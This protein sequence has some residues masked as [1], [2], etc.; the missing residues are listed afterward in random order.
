MEHSSK[1]A[2]P[3]QRLQL[4]VMKFAQDVFTSLLPLMTIRFPPPQTTFASNAEHGFQ[5]V[6]Q[7]LFDT[8]YRTPLCM[9]YRTSSWV[10]IEPVS[11]GSIES[12]VVSFVLLS[13]MR[14]NTYWYKQFIMKVP[15]ADS[16]SCFDQL[17]GSAEPS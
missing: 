9:L 7:E 4:Y 16:R 1:P 3:I 8:F 14:L 5:K 10:S 15:E 6:S 2:D 11:L 12:F 13:A 17:E